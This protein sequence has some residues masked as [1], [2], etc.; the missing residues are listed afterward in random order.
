MGNSIDAATTHK[1]PGETG[2]LSI[3]VIEMGTV[4]GNATV[5]PGLQVGVVRGNRRRES[6]ARKLD[7]AQQG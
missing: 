3:K 6:S 4:V 7:V 5:G 2:G 1:L